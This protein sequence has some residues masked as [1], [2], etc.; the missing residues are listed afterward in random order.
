MKTLTII[1]LITILI[2]FAAQTGA[3]SL[4]KDSSSA[5]LSDN[6]ACKVGDII[7]IIV[8]ESASSSADASTEAS[9]DAKLKADAGLG[10]FLT[11][12]PELEAGGGDETSTSGTTTR[13]TKLTA[14][15]SARI[16]AVDEAGNFVLEGTRVVQTNEERQEMKLTG[17]VRPQDIEPDNTVLSHYVANAEITYTGKGPLGRRQREG[18][19]TQILRFLF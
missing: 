2:A 16:T 14:R 15:L 17:T 7:T 6:K 3:E 19:I 18:I 5:L 13:K 10:P 12:I 1:L 4:W 8:S 11:M 9:K